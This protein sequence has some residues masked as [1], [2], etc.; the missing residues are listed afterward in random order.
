MKFSHSQFVKN[1]EGSYLHEWLKSDAEKVSVFLH[2]ES[3]KPFVKTVDYLNEL[4]GKEPQLRS[5]AA[6]QVYPSDD[7]WLGEECGLNSPE[8]LLA[9]LRLS[10]L[11][12]QDNG[13]GTFQTRLVYVGPNDFQTIT[14]KHVLLVDVPG[15][16]GE[17]DTNFDSYDED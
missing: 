4:V 14:A 7:F 17:F 16:G 15:F 1:D 5:E 3:G 9:V 2:A 12:V 8:E 13:D 6:H 11:D 10:I